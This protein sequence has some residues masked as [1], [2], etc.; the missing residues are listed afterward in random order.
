MTDLKTCFLIDDDIDD[1]EIFGLAIKEIDYSIQ[2]TFANDGAEALQKL[3]TTALNFLPDYI[4][5]DLNM[6]GA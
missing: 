4:F 2:C 6:P 5:L 3:S 1:Q